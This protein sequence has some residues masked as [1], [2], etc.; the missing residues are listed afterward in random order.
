MGNCYLYSNLLYGLS[1][2]YNSTIFFSA[3]GGFL[4]IFGLF[5]MVRFNIVEKFINQESIVLSSSGVTGPPLS[6]EER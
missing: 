2:T 6:V 5:L 3:S 1:Q 4:T